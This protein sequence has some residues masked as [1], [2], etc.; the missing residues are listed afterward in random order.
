MASIG[1]MFASSAAEEDW[2]EIRVCKHWHTWKQMTLVV[3]HINHAWN[4]MNALARREG[5]DHSMDEMADSTFL[6]WPKLEPRGPDRAAR[7]SA[8]R[9]ATSTSSS[10]PT[11]TTGCTH[12]ETNRHGSNQYVARMNCK[13]CDMVVASVKVGEMTREEVQLELA[14]QWAQKQRESIGE[15]QKV[16]EKSKQLEENDAIQQMRAELEELKR[17]T[18]EQ[19]ASN[20]STGAAASL[21]RRT[22]R[23]PVDVSQMTRDCEC[24]RKMVVRYNR[25]DGSAFWGCEGYP[26][27]QCTKTLPFRPE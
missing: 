17:A 21:S 22:S 16:P 11:S 9:A 12:K 13:A 2:A 20:P 26:T 8:P 1:R 5:E 3:M 10:T 4:V 7:T 24:G 19:V 6:A 27:R 18:S 15:T 14:K 23:A 25:H